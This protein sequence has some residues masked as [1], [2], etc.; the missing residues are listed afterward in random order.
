MSAW[1]LAGVIVNGAWTQLDEI[2]WLAG[3]PLAVV[4]AL[5][6]LGRDPRF[7][8][9]WQ[10]AQRPRQPPDAAPTIAAA[11]L[12]LLHVAHVAIT[13]REEFGF[14]G[15][16]GYHL[17]ATRAFALYYL[18]AAPL[19]A[20]ALAVFAA[21]RWRRWPYAA[22]AAMA[23]LLASSL[24]LPPSALFGRYPA[25]FYLL[26]APLNVAFELG[27]FASPFTANHLMNALS[28]P[29]WLFVLRPLVTGRW[30]DW[31]V[32]PAALIL[33][34]QGPAFV[35]VASTL[36]EPWAVVF[37]LLA[38][39][40][41]V[42]LPEDQ[43]WKAIVLAALAAAFKETAVLLLPTVWLLACV[44]WRQRRPSLR[45]AAVALG[46]A[47][48][49]PFAVYY[50][51]RLDA[52]I[53]RT[54]TVALFDDAWRPARL[55]EWLANVRAALGDT[56][57]AS[58]ALLWVATLRHGLPWSVTALAVLVF[59]HVDALSMPW[60]GYSRYLAFALVAL[61]GAVLATTHRIGNRRAL[62]GISAIVIAL[63]AAPVARMLALDFRPDYERNSLEW[64]G[65]L[66]RLPIRS[67]IERLP[68][69]PGG[70][71]R[72]IRVV[73][74]ATDLTSL[75]VAYPDIARR[76]EL[77]RADGVGMAACRCA[78][79]SEAVLAVFEW[80]AHFADTADARG[81]FDDS[82]A[83]CVRQIDATCRAV[84]VERDY[85]GAPVGIIGVGV[86]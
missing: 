42:I 74:F 56:A 80:P 37:L 44:T 39:E 18:R 22:S 69:P 5:D 3:I 4:L 68:A 71:A 65:S 43:R 64:N 76:Y 25:G 63:Q 35:Y 73:T 24:L 84:E 14:G 31:Q 7:R 21:A 20:V 30:P 66:I 79:N 6:R 81:A 55:A 11:L 15:D 32:L 17:S 52:D 19:L 57:L 78:D 34:F 27:R 8:V 72:S 33:Y 36:I 40:A 46:V 12:C 50:L 41:L 61:A 29:A 16:E 48:A 47:A 28:V 67:L 53:H 83:R 10:K 62:I 82:S 26:A 77:R 86:R 38:L 59:F 23:V 1:V 49:T 58:M 9:P 45:G 85:R 2:G 51:V 60:T 54:V 75:Q 70:G 13:A